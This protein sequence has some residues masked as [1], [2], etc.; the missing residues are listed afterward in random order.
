MAR[1]H[2]KGR[3]PRIKL[4]RKQKRNNWRA[5]IDEGREEVGQNF[6]ASRIFWGLIVGVSSV[7]IGLYHPAMAQ[8][9]L[10]RDRQPPREPDRGSGPWNQFPAIKQELHPLDHPLLSDELLRNTHGVIRLVAQQDFRETP[11]QHF[12]IPAGA[13][14]IRR[15]RSTDSRAKSQ[16]EFCL[17]RCQDYGGLGS[18]SCRTTGV[19]SRVC[20]KGFW[21]VSNAIGTIERVR[22][23]RWR[24]FHRRFCAKSSQPGQSR[25]IRTS[26][27]S[28][29]LPRQQVVGRL[30]QCSES[31]ERE[32]Y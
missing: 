31:L 22:F 3:M 2:G 10:G 24:L 4:K 14:G 15:E 18:Y 32:V 7:A 5:R 17:Y 27:R 21:H 9:E 13:L 30:H 19:R 16:R 11:K 29:I 26:R 20:R 6:S 25:C 23:R 28:S 8:D 12:E 1:Q